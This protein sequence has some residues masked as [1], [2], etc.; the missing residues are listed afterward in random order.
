MQFSGAALRRGFTRPRAVLLVMSEKRTNLTVTNELLRRSS[1]RQCPSLIH[2]QFSAVLLS[3]PPL[4][5]V[6]H[7]HVSPAHQFCISLCSACPEVEEP[8]AGSR[9]LPFTHAGHLFQKLS[10]R[11]LAPSFARVSNLKCFIYLHAWRSPRGPSE[12]LL[13]FNLPVTVQ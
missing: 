8:K 7:T 11:S 10:L 5:F 13:F 4:S 3:L 12:L 9:S 6:A 1:N 2:L